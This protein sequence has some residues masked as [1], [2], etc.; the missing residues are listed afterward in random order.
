M[1]SFR[2]K[3][4]IRGK[5]VFDEL[6]NAGHVAVSYPYRAHW[7]KTDSQKYPI[8]VAFSIPKRRFKNAVT[9]NLIKRRISEIYRLNKHSFYNELRKKNVNL[10]LYIIYTGSEV[11][12]SY[13]LK[14]PLLTIIRMIISQAK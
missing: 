9:R 7:M 10:K 14:K 12:K 8:Q 11:L 3:E 5:L 4:K 13:R 6:F 2:K 1:F